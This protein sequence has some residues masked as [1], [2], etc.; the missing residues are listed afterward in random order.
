MEIQSES[1]HVVDTV[2][3]G[4]LQQLEHGAL[5]L[6]LAL[7]NNGVVTAQHHGVSSSLVGLR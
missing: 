5:A 2:H 6:L 4:D 3:P 1:K 7:V